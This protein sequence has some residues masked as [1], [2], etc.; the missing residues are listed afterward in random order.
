MGL[1]HLRS[2]PDHR[3]MVRGGKVNSQLNLIFVTQAGLKQKPKNASQSQSETQ[4]VIEAV[5][6]S[7]AREIIE[8]AMGYMLYHR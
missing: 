2:A 7:A 1:N 4:Q 5:S 6:L 3:K 8:A